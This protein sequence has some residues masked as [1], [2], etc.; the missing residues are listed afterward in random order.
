[1]NTDIPKANSSYGQILKSSSIIGGGEMLTQLIGLIRTKVVAILL[2]P[3][4][5]GLVGLY[6]SVSGFMGTIALLGINQSGVRAVAEAAAEGDIQKVSGVAK[7]L[8]RACWITGL[9][10][11][12]L[13]VVMA[14]PL[15]M[16]TFESPS[17][18][19]VIALLGCTVMFT[20]LAGG[21]T[22]LINGV[23]RV[24]DLARIQVYASVLT[25]ILAVSVY[26]MFKE[27]GI[28]PVII[29][30]GAIQGAVSWFFARK[31]SLVPVDQTWAE[32]VSN[33]RSL[34]SLGIA[35][36][37][38][39][40]LVSAVGLGTRMLVV[41]EE[42]LEANGFYQAA[43]MVS[44][45]L[46]SFVLAAM[47]R[48]FYPRLTSVHTDPEKV[49]RLVN[50][51]IEVGILLG[52]PGLVATVAFAPILIEILYSSK[53]L[54]SAELLPYFALGV[55]VRLI[56]W[57]LGF[58]LLAKNDSFKYALV[59]TIFQGTQLALTFILLK[60]YGLTGAAIAF[61]VSELIQLLLYH[62]V[63]R[64]LVRLSVSSEVRRLV[65]LGLVALSIAYLLGVNAHNP[66]VIILSVLITFFAASCS[67]SGL[68]ARLPDSSKIILFLRRTPLIRHLLQKT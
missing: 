66:L 18:T 29:L 54:P 44:G 48:D 38:A 10:G 13:T 28:I 46:A 42:G 57:P 19:A 1:M 33:L 50:E 40:L 61:V 20:A 14:Y 4:G 60:R 36:M 30:T 8:R 65:F 23:R 6:V 31:I 21:E 34:V 25:T 67:I 49:D 53:F 24:G 45:M 5:M 12:L 37:Y 47:G 11:W 15:S 32:T 17:H 59:A 43:W 26:A 7:T 62:A 41:R 39:G 55:F 9:L 56:S 3:S 51:Q 2:G 35:F 68:S 27:R 63:G 64:R 22:A 16:W 58:I 52:L